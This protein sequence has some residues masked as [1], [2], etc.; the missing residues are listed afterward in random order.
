MTGEQNTRG[1]TKVSEKIVTSNAQ[2]RNGGS[3]REKKGRF[4]EN[5]FSTIQL[6]CNLL[7]IYWKP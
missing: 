3:A 1:A 4:K 5:V 2:A 6:L 7:R